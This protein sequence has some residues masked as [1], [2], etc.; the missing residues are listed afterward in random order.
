MECSAGYWRNI[1]C[2]GLVEI[3]GHLPFHHFILILV[4][5][6]EAGLL[7]VA[8]NTGF[9]GG[10][11]VLANMAIDNWVPK[12]FRNLSSRLVTQNGILLFGVA[13]LLILLG[14]DGEV[15]ILVVLYSINVFLTFSLSLLGLCIYW[16]KHRRAANWLIRIALS[17]IGF[18]VCAAI[19]LIMILEKFTA[20][21]WVNDYYY[22]CRNR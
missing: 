21:G 8:A 6:F 1:K 17:I 7:L 19:L 18:I 3:F 9:L 2:S 13:A 10:P 20:G 16:F 12:Q 5:F 4:L 22:Q 15:S 14:T 11:A